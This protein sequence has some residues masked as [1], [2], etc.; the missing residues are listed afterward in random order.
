MLNVN[1]EVLVRLGLVLLLASCAHE[2]N[3]MKDTH[4]WLED[5]TLK[6]TQDWVKKRNEKSAS[7]LQGDP[8]FL[9]VAADVRAILTASERIPMPSRR[10]DVILNFWQDQNHKRGI[11]RTTN[12]TEYQKPSPKWE[13]LLDIDELNR[14]EK[15]SWV[16]KG[17]QCFWP[18]N[19]LCLIELSDGGRDEST[20]REFQISKRNWVQGG[21]EVPAAKSNVS[22]I[23]QD[24]LFI[25][26]DFGEG[27]L[28]SSGYPRQI[29][30][31]KRGTPLKEAKLVFEGAKEDV[32]VGAWRTL[33]TE[34]KLMF[35]SQGLNFFES[36]LFVF[37]GKSTHLVPFPKSADYVGNFHDV[38]LARLRDNWVTPIKTFKAGSVV[39][40][41]ESA[42]D[43]VNALNE[44]REVFVPDDRSSVQSVSLS[45]DFL[46]INVLRNVKSELFR[47]EQKDSGWVSRPISFRENGVISVLGNNETDNQFLVTFET[48]NEPTSL[49]F[50]DF[51]KGQAF[52]KVKSLPQQFDAR[53]IV[54]QQFESVSR[55]GTKIPYFLVHKKGLVLDGSNPTLLYGYGGFESTEAPFYSGTIG[56]VWL[57]KGGVFA[58]ANIRGG[59]EFGP[60]WHEAALKENRQRAFDDFA[61]VARDLQSR[62]ITSARRLGIKGGSNG[63]LLVGVSAMQTPELYHAV[64][65]EAALLD[66]IR[67]TELPPGASWIGEYGDP[68]DQKMRDVIAKYSPYQNIKPNVTYPQIFFYTSTADDRVQPGHTR[69]MVARLEDNGHDVLMYENTE[70]G[71]GGAADLEQSVK[72]LA[73]EYVYLYQKL[74]D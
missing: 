62:K 36:K 3:R 23:D 21:F 44:V 55:D 18:E 12:W 15:K 63:G 32:S 60:R 70:G 56:K 42:I 52:K 47:A 57:E 51:S 14:L 65:C 17:V 8:R 1:L 46:T 24:T 48:F 4:I 9:K 66:M 2:G 68:K 29:R 64:I 37:D 41:P 59:G 43:S 50:A 6:D 10:G 71:H 38:L 54:I 27:T 22:W 7:L 5:S 67:Y 45:K 34:S 53:D 74:M 30:V 20:L 33:T 26:T 13:T 49:Y 39:S 61:S 11:W 73:L 40:L 72:K 35:F 25:S 31:W 19:D 58:L 28:T 69:K 16:F